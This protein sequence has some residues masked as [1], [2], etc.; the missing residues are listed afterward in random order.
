MGITLRRD[1]TQNQMLSGAIQIDADVNKEAQ[2]S[3]SCISDSNGNVLVVLMCAVVLTD[4]WRF[5]LLRR[6]V[7]ITGFKRRRFVDIQKG[8]TANGCVFVNCCIPS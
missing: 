2:Y 6:V 8:T 7:V 4:D 5:H 3:V 1:A